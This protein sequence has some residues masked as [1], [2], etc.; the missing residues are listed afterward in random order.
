MSLSS[1]DSL[2]TKELAN[3]F[4][5]LF[6]RIEILVYLL[7]PSFL[8]CFMIIP[9]NSRINFYNPHASNH[10]HYLVGYMS[11]YNKWDAILITLARI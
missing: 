7:N 5:G 6:L 10:F 3:S 2:L 1:A 8:E 9:I 4:T 11:Q